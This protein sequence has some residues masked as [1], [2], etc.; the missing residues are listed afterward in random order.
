MCCTVEGAGRGGVAKLVD[1]SDLKSLGFG[2]TGSNPVAPT[3][4][5][6]SDPPGMVHLPKIDIGATPTGVVTP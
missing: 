5:R 3:M 1:A 4:A 2:L 6:A